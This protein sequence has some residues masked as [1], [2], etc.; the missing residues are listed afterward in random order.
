MIPP[1]CCWAWTKWTIRAS[2][3]PRLASV[4][5]IVTTF[6]SGVNRAASAA[7][8]GSTLGKDRHADKRFDY[9]LANPPFGK[10]WKMDQTA[11]EAEQRAWDEQG[12]D[13]NHEVFPL[14]NDVRDVLRTNGV[15]VRPESA[16]CGS[17]AFCGNS[18]LARTTPRALTEPD[19]DGEGLAG[20]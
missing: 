4:S 16:L 7:Q 6:R 13:W 8:F 2:G 17:A 18:P 5:P 9:L 12:E 19:Q 10:E 15:P 1:W 14:I 11:V 20:R 3:W